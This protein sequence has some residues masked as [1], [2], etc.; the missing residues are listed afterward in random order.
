MLE[1]FVAGRTFDGFRDDQMFQDAVVRR[2]E[3][4][5]EAAAHV[6][7]PMRDRHPEVAWRSIIAFRNFAIHVYFSLD[8]AIVWTTATVNAPRLAS[9][10]DRIVDQEYHQEPG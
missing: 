9:L 2:L 8:L 5:G 3:V 6:S 1:G 10:I 4:L 7:A